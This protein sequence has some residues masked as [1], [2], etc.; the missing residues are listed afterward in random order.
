MGN[1]LNKSGNAVISIDASSSNMRMVLGSYNRKNGMIY[2]DKASVIGLESDTIAD[3]VINDQ[4]GVV[5]AM[6]NALAKMD[7]QSKHA[8]FTVEGSYLHTR[9]LEL[10]AVRADQLTDMVRYEI[11]G[12]GN[13]NRD[14]IV[15]YIIYD[16][17][18]DEETKQPK[19]KVRAT[20]IPKEVAIDFR[21]LMKTSALSPVALDV[22]PNAVRKL[23]STG[24]INGTTNV[25]S[26]TLL[27]IELSSKTTNITVLDKGFPV[28][29]RRLQFGHSNI[30]QVAETVKKVQGNGA[31][32]SSILT[33]RLQVVKG[34][35][36]KTVDISDIDVWHE[37]VKDEPSLNSAVSAYFKS[38][39]DAISRTAQ[40]SITKYRLDSISTCFLYGSG[41]Q[42]RKMDKELSRQL[43]T[44]V[45]VL[46]TLNTVS[47]PKD[48]I[49][50]DYVN[51]CGALIRE[52]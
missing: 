18:M 14:M 21:E 44:Q 4:F 46:N 13:N 40:F 15:E 11:L 10:P 5:M 28:L 12:Q 35:G 3:G 42:Y 33:R 26:N 27:L 34:E 43:G 32:K 17:V 49:L 51:A 37:S 48:F 45:E 24:T 31:D 23:F 39:T 19:Y 8:I 52:N 41:A 47:G 25:E 16:K 30:R 50:S 6:K 38:L 29:T 2:V 20:A 36:V 22:N 1:P 7:V 9:D